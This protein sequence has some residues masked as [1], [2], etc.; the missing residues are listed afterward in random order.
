MIRSCDVG[1]LP[2]LGDEERFLE[3]AT[4]IQGSAE[5][6]V[7][8]FEEKVAEG[9]LHKVE[10][11]IDVP[12][13]PQFRDMNR[14][15]LEMMQ[16]VEKTEEG[17]METDFLSLKAGKTDIPE[18]SAIREKIPDIHATVGEPLQLRVCIT[19]PYTLSWLFIHR[20]GGI[21]KRL[22][23]VVSRLVDNNFLRGAHGRVVIVAVDEP[24]F[25][26]LDDPLIDP[27]SEG[28]ENLRRAWQTILQKA[29]SRGSQTCLHLH[30]TA[31]R[32]FWEVESLDI[33]ESHA[34]DP[35]YERERTRGLL[36]STDKFLKASI[37]ITDF[38][39]LI[40]DRIV[41]DSEQELNEL[42]LNQRVAEI[43]KNLA[44]GQLKPETFLEDQDLMQRRLTRAIEEFGAERVP[45]AGPECGLRSFPTYRSAIECLKRVSKVV[46]SFQDL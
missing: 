33:I 44:S 36:E 24:T 41:A 1:S 3:G 5:E 46:K 32:L 27:G 29:H 14:M 4:A 43:W 21:F 12:S 26:L 7:R 10:A 34:E 16:G 11:G 38:D 9:L 45:Y 18:I 40:R 37:S 2:L 6:A 31:D 8:Y 25:G 22:G 28:R 20:D 17:Y 19:G 30:N 23:E 39:R 13:Y 42:L 15:F 35:L